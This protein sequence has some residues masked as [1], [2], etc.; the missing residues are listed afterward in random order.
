M[1]GYWIAEKTDYKPG[2]IPAVSKSGDFERVG[3]YT[4]LIWRNTSRVG[5]A[6]ASG[7]REDVLVCR[8]SE[9]GNVVGE[10]AI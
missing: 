6:L 4:Q 3:H 8:Y 1:V 5:C 2:P 9:G 7:T 10:R